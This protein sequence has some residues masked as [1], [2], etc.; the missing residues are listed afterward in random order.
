MKNLLHIFIFFALYL[1]VS[2]SCKKSTGSGEACYFAADPAMGFI[3][4]A[5]AR[6]LSAGGNFIISLN[7]S[8]TLLSACNLQ[9]S[10]KIDG[11][12]VLV[13]GEVKPTAQN[14]YDPCHCYNFLIT[15]I[16]R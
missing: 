13:S 14:T 1:L 10:Y 5:P 8:D 9:G 7:S 11:L 6:I 4:N 12:N 3:N 2:T 16:I 15:K